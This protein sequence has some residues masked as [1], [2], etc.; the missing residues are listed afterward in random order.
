MGNHE[1]RISL[2]EQPMPTASVEHP[3]PVP[4]SRFALLVPLFARLPVFLLAII[5][6]AGGAVRLH[7]FN[8]SLA[9]TPD[10]FTYTRQALIERALGPAGFRLLGQEFYRN[11]PMV[12]R[13]PSPARFGFI[14]LVVA[15][16]RITGENSPLAGAYISLLASLL[17]LILIAYTAYRFLS[18]AVAVVATLFYAVFPFDLTIYRRAWEEAIIALLAMATLTLAAWIPSLRGSRFYAFLT[19]FTALGLLCFATKENSAIVFLLSAAGL[20]MQF[21]LRRNRRAAVLTACCALAAVVA[22]TA[23][24]AWLFGGFMRSMNLVIEYIHYS[25]I[26]PYSVQFDSGPIWMFP[27]AFFRASPF[28]FV[29][30]LV[31]FAVAIYRAIRARSLPEEGLPLGV[32]LITATM[33][34]LQLVTH[35]YSFRYAAPIFGPACLLAGIGADAVLPRLHRI[36]APFG[37]YTAWAVV[38]FAIAVAALRDFNVARDRF[39]LPA[40]QDLAMRPILGVPPAPVPPDYSR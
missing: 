5:I 8:P 6:A 29:A 37:R 19:A 18:P 28:L 11:P 10:E 27:A 13:Y 24:L 12:S 14:S 31:G 16:M 36:L 9:R 34:L 32:A 20:V 33:V 40:M 15:S 35:R 22:Y 38:G 3:L 23:I 1:V 17:T 39:L 26:N 4:P 30:S 7:Y 2:L 21:Y 25:G